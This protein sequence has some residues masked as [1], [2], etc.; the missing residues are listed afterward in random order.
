[1]KWSAWVSAW[2]RIRF[3]FRR[4]SEQRALDA[5]LRFHV[6]MRAAEL[7]RAGHTKEGARRM[8]ARAV[9]DVMRWREATVAVVSWTWL[10]LL[11]RDVRFGMR[12][13]GRGGVASVTVVLTLASG[14][15]GVLAVFTL[16][17]AL[18]LRPVPYAQPDRLAVAYRALTPGV[19]AASDTLPI[20][21][22]NLEELRTLVPA[23]RDAGLGAWDELNLD[24]GGGADRIRVGL[25]QGLFRVLRVPAMLGRTPA[26]DEE[27]AGARVAV[28]T[29]AFWKSHF[30]GDAGALGRD[31]VLAGVRFTVIGVMPPA[32]A[33]LSD[34]AIL[35]IPA[36]AVSGFAPG[37][38]LRFRRGESVWGTVVVR[39][40]EGVSLSS[41]RQQFANALP[42]LEASDLLF[43]GSPDRVMEA[44]LMPMAEAQQHAV[45]R[46]VLRLLAAAVAVVLLLVLANVVGL[47]LV[48]ARARG[49]ELAVRTALGAGRG[50]LLRQLMLE[51][52]VLALAGG[53]LGILLGYLGALALARMRPDLPVTA[54]SLVLLRGANLSETAIVPDAGVLGA[55]LLLSL[56]VGTSMGI[57]TA[58]GAFRGSAQAM[59]AGSAR[60]YTPAPRG[61]AA[62]V[63]MQ[64]ALAVAL[65]FGAG[66]TLRSFR[67]LMRTDIGFDADPVLVARL[68]RSGSDANAPV[69]R[70]ELMAR[71]A[72][73]PGVAAVAAAGTTPFDS[74]DIMYGAITRVDDRAIADGELPPFQY[75]NVS[76]DYFRALGIPIL[77]G[78]AFDTSRP[79]PGDVQPVVVNE[80]AARL[81]WP[82]QDPVGH[83]IARG[84]EVQHVVGV[85][86]DVRYERIQAAAGPAVYSLASDGAVTTLFVRARGN[87]ASLLPAVRSTVADVEPGTAVFAATTLRETV[88]EA[89]SETRYVT[90]LLMAFGSA[91]VLLAAIGVYGV[92]AYAVHERR[93]EFGVRLAVGA[94]PRELVA[95]VMRQG[96][97]LLAT[98]LA[99]G[100]LLGLAGAGVLRAFLFEVQP[101]DP[102]TLIAIAVILAVVGGLATW[103]PA[104]RAGRV[105]PVTA[106][107]M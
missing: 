94:R 79:S 36:R 9:G 28:L 98:G 96:L 3:L 83:R 65:L 81:L 54:A 60:T 34:G 12:S 47:M 56:M 68:A 64:L 27:L 55:A 74:E 76:A 77:R 88:R 80:A 15:G 26:E 2:H 48:R 43:R 17:R 29:H 89:A 45:I 63:T 35:W 105:D 70:D 86:G 4:G 100:M 8:A 16:A 57:V 87:P 18:V 31:I 91:A 40:P 69:R 25:T 72:G 82:G 97:R 104:A 101:G 20:G 44:G 21:L 33:G 78:R 10:D 39:L 23:L 62:L 61:R 58:A 67:A 92:L 50:Q 7:E 14:I 5:E 41:A 42:S 46:S 6:E 38:T 71:L 37:S 106:L 19:F 107:R 103:L 85:A 90:R 22:A 102:T 49:G 59:L 52:H 99:F 51:S 24:R 53:A 73:L 75:H 84:D 93:R 66:L 1:M 30:Q 95:A 32:F 13:L 11:L